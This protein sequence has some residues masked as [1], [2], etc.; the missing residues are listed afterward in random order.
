MFCSKA[1]LVWFCT[2]VL[3]SKLVKI[4]LRFYYRPADL[5]YLPGYYFVAYLHSLVKLYVMFFESTEYG[6]RNVKPKAKAES[7]PSSSA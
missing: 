6:G 1:T 7:S 3:S 5:I 2:W 4:M